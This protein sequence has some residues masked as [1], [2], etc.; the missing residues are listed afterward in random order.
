MM[1]CLGCDEEYDSEW[2][3]IECEQ[4]HVL[5]VLLAAGVR[6]PYTGFFEKSE[7]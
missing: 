5:E 6:S 3:V 7:E 4:K 2:D 1:R